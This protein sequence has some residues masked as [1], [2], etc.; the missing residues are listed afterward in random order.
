MF[1]DIKDLQR[2]IIW[3]KNNKLKSFKRGDLSFELSE[4]SFVE[5]LNQT[6]PDDTILR[7]EA[8]LEELQQL[9]DN[10]DAL[11]WSSSS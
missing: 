1:K 11:F 4:L 3:C 10:E 9:E 8:K 7:D 2:F 6:V 5:G